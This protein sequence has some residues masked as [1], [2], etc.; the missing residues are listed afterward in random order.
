MESVAG[1]LRFDS[2]ADLSDA[3]IFFWFWAVP[4]LDMLLI[5]D[6]NLTPFILP[7]H[8]LLT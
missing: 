2:A 7:P 1:L 3:L 4:C 8:S 5:L 6:M